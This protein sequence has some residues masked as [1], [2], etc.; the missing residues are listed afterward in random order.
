MS[1]AN[2]IN[3][4]PIFSRYLIIVYCTVLIFSA[5]LVYFLPTAHLVGTPANADY[6]NNQARETAAVTQAPIL[7]RM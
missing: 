6:H 1:R 2:R 5:V 3:F 4:K 7:P